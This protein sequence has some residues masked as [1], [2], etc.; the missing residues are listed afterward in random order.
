M[1]VPYQATQFTT[2]EYFRKILNPSQQYS[3]STHIMAG[4]IAGS[5]AAVLTTPLD[6]VK[7]VLQTRGAEEIDQGARKVSGIKSTIRIVYNSRGI[8]GFFSG[9]R[10]RV[11]TH[12]PST[13]ICWTVYEYFKWFIMESG[14]G[15]D[16][17]R[18]AKRK[19]QQ[20]EISQIEEEQSTL[21]YH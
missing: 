20:R 7:T 17:A 2:Y 16:N 5:V 18:N 21:P 6:V 3:P 4:G 12:M 8:R 19:K 15:S 10:P 11:I 9:W 13:A 1:T 14:G